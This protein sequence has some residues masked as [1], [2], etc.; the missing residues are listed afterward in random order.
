MVV[1][2]LLLADPSSTLT[3]KHASHVWSKIMELSWSPPA[4]PIFEYVNNAL[5]GRWVELATHETGCESLLA[6]IYDHMLI[7]LLSSSC[8]S[9]SV[10]KLWSGRHERL[11]ARNPWRVWKGRSGS[12]GFLRHPTQW[13]SPSVLFHSWLINDF[14][15]AWT[16]PTFSSRSGSFSPL[17]EVATIFHGQSSHEVD[18]ESSQRLSWWCARKDRSETHRFWHHVSR[19]LVEAS[20]S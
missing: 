19:V 11:L 1:S 20:W 9:T 7:E 3:N 5:R 16:W 13:V 2:E 12:M 14:H 10:R 18:R 17:W 15:S 6:W 8:H 4:P